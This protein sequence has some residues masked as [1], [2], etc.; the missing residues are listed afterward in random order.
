[1]ES[2]GCWF[3]L[4]GIAV[5]LILMLAAT[6]DRVS[7]FIHH[8]LGRKSSDSGSSFG[9]KSSGP[10]IRRNESDAVRDIGFGRLSDRDY[11]SYH[12]SDGGGSYSGGGDSY[13]G[14]GGSDSGGG[15]SYSGGGY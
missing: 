5:F 2:W 7:G 9:R 15:G 11:G 1:M 14:G 12:I 3:G 8:I 13:S 10:T 6:N 4:A